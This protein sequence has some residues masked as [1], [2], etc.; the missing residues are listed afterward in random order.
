MSNLGPD[1]LTEFGEF[2]SFKSEL[3]EAPNE[4]EPFID[5]IPLSE[6]DVSQ[7]PT[8]QQIQKIVEEAK[9]NSN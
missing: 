9:A 2:I 7:S 8:F 6:V 4:T 1:Y 3:K 5:F